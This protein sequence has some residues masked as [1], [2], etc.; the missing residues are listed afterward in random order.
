MVV[1]AVVVAVFFVVAVGVVV[2]VV[3]AG[4][5]AGAGA[6]CGSLGNESAERVA[7][8]GYASLTS[9]TPSLSSSGSQASPR[10][11]RSVSSW[12]G[13]AT[14]GQLSALPDRPSPSGSIGAPIAP[15]APSASSRPPVTDFPASA[16]TGLAPCRIACLSWA[17]VALGL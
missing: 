11:S 3:G 4:A 9:A 10:P 2:V 5:G 1:V 17:T 16:A 15:R 6:G 12:S 8:S 14:D 7:S 13:L